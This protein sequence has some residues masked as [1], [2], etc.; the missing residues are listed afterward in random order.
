MS[1]FSRQFKRGTHVTWRTAP[2]NRGGVSLRY[3]LRAGEGRH[4]LLFQR[5][6]KTKGNALFQVHAI[7][8]TF[9]K[10]GGAH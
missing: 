1:A 5:R 4:P 3:R 10:N 9:W 7:H 6:R 8:G 2:G